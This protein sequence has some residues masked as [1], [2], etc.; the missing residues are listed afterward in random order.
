MKRKIKVLSAFIVAVSLCV[1]M[2]GVTGI[3]MKN[4][5]TTATMK[6]YSAAKTESTTI[7]TIA[8]ESSFFIH[9]PPSAFFSVFCQSEIV[10]HS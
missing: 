7:S 6:N 4:D 8:K 5:V 9:Y 3:E 2:F 10:P 1:T